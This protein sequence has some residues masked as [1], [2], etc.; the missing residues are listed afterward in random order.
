MRELIATEQVLRSL[1]EGIR[2]WV[3]ERKPK[4]A[5]EVRQLAEDYLQARRPLQGSKWM[6]AL[7]ERMEGESIR[8]CF[9]CKQVGDLARD[10]P[11]H[12]SG[13]KANGGVRKARIELKC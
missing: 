11:K 10:C 13:W 8:R 7:G 1:P 2:V 4:T 9:E 6:K 12:Q 5:A 3:H